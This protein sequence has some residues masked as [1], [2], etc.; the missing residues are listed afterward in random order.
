MAIECNGDNFVKFT[1]ANY[2]FPISGV[3]KCVALFG[4]GSCIRLNRTLDSFTLVE[5]GADLLVA[6]AHPAGV[7]G[8]DRRPGHRRFQRGVWVYS[9][10]APTPIVATGSA[11]VVTGLL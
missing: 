5:I 8:I 2:G 10:T 7:R 11:R 6:P 1:A 9:T 3:S 4:L